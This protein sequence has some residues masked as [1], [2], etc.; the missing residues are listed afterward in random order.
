VLAGGADFPRSVIAAVF[1][2]LCVKTGLLITAIRSRT[3]IRSATTPIFRANL[4]GP[5]IAA[6]M[7]VVV[8]TSHFIATGIITAGLL[9]A[10]IINPALPHTIGP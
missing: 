1:P 10:D 4:S 9:A 5:I 7:G 3:A 2:G 8:I 6:L